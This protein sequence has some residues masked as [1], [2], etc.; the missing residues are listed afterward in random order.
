MKK[1]FISL[2]MLLVAGTVQAQIS[3]SGNWYNGWLTYSAKNMAN[4]KVLM[5]AMAEGEEHEFMLVPVGGKKDT[6]S[7][8]DGPNDYVNEYSGIA[9]VRHLTQD[10]WD[11]L[12][13]YNAKNQLETVMSCEQEWDAEKLN[14][15]KFKNQLIGEY[16]LVG[17]PDDELNLVINWDQVSVNLELT[18]YKVETFN[19][20]VMGYITINPIEGST[21]RLVGTWEV[22]PTLEGLKLYSSSFNEDDNW[23]VRNGNVLT[24]RKAQSTLRR[25]GY[26]SMGLL[27][28]R[29][30]RTMKKSTLR[31][32]RNEI[33]ASHGYRFESED[34]QEYF[35]RQPWYKPAI[36]NDDIQLSFIE[37]LN[38]E[39]IKGEESN[40]DHDS[41]VKEP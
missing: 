9:T 7:V 38:V 41:Y 1:S 27:N 6:Y 37:R 18:S 16:E 30:F 5:N 28:N 21:D 10:G 22:V 19:G 23:W 20:L 35:N 13:F 32:M 2:L 11:V 24:F 3:E 31:I 4:G 33:L 14:V 12:C 36:S 40:P 29:Q 17:D 39:L 25:F 15:A 34:L 26:A 8:A